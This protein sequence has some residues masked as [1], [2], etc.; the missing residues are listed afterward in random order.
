MGHKVSRHKSYAVCRVDG[1]PGQY[2]VIR[3]D[4]SYKSQPNPYARSNGNSGN[5]PSRDLGVTADRKYVTAI[6]DIGSKGI[7]SHQAEPKQSNVISGKS[8]PKPKPRKK[9]DINSNEKT[10]GNLPKQTAPIPT[11]RKDSP[12]SNA[13]VRKSNGFAIHEDTIFH[14]DNTRNGFIARSNE[15]SIQERPQRV[16]PRA[17]PSESDERKPKSTSHANPKSV[18]ERKQKN[19]QR[20]NFTESETRREIK[21]SLDYEHEPLSATYTIDTKVVED[22]LIPVSNVDSAEINTKQAM[23]YLESDTSHAKF[24]SDSTVH[25]TGNDV[26][27]STSQVNDDTPAY[28]KISPPEESVVK[29][30]S[31]SNHTLVSVVV[32]QPFIKPEP[33]DIPEVVLNDDQKCLSDKVEIEHQDQVML[34][35]EPV[36]VAMFERPNSA[37]SSQIKKSVAFS[38]ECVD[39]EHDLSQSYSRNGFHEKMD[40]VYGVKDDGD[41]WVT[42]DGRNATDFALVQRQKVPGQSILKKSKCHPN[43]ATTLDFRDSCDSLDFKTKLKKEKSEFD[44]DHIEDPSNPYPHGMV[45]VPAPRGRMKGYHRPQNAEMTKIKASNG[46]LADYIKQKS[47]NSHQATKTSTSNGLNHNMTIQN[48]GPR[49]HSSRAHGGDMS[50]RYVTSPRSTSA[51]P[52]SR[53]MSPTRVDSRGRV[54]LQDGHARKR[55]NGYIADPAV[56]Y[57]QSSRGKEV[58]ALDSRSKTRQVIP[59]QK[60]NVKLV[61]SSGKQKSSKKS[62]HTVIIEQPKQHRNMVRQ[63]WMVGNL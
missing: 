39:I 44:W 12:K 53:A 41:K 40:T 23:S 25:K 20:A 1:L 55:V 47:A 50:P 16:L 59:P 17:N 35:D 24:D 63:Q 38:D 9:K 2:R 49:P 62:Q 42:L 10:N 14:Q 4:D 21:S 6:N 22:E 26:E 56:H 60:Q 34:D 29:D 27:I 52:R 57:V 28:T 33:S 3:P 45:P 7:R 30:S 54:V 13:V 32:H 19:S 48:G 36:D 18:H 8:K 58:T 37:R 51:D 5:Y 61:V 31:R 11:K 15:T 43:Q 46:T